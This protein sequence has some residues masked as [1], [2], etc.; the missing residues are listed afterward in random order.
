MTRQEPR[1]VPRLVIEAVHLDQVREHGGLIGIRDENALE[2]GL[3][4]ARQ[5]WTLD[6]D[7][8]LSRL[9][10]GYVFGTCT[11]HPFRD[12][13]KRIS[14]LAAVIFLGLNG[15]DLVAPDEVVVEKMMGIASGKLVEEA[16]A[17]WLRSRIEPRAVV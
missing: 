16:I 5:R 1:W 11:G 14:F 3:V 2:S 8:D 6:P 7:S 17:D 13:N 15:F 4:R 10:A 9:A 12:G